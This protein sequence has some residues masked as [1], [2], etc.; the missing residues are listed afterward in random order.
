MIQIAA[1]SIDQINACWDELSSLLQKAIDYSNG[2]LDIDSVKERILSGEIMVVVVFKD[3]NLIAAVTFE[4]I[5][6]QTC[7]R[8]LNIQLAGG[9]DI[10]LW[11]HDVEKIA[12]GLAERYHCSDVYIIGR[13]GWVRKMKSLGYSEVHTILHKE[14]K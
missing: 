10:E 11:F 1:P 13:K 3:G 4:Q 6:F 12:N 9:T 8:V 2:E 14:V 7:K 5:E